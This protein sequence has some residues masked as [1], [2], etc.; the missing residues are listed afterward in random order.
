MSSLV[1]VAE[2]SLIFSNEASKRTRT[3]ISVVEPPTHNGAHTSSLRVNIAL[4]QQHPSYP[5]VSIIPP[6]PTSAKPTSIKSAT[7][8]NSTLH[9]YRFLSEHTTQQDT[10]HTIEIPELLDWDIWMVMKGS[11]F[12]RGWW[13][14]AIP[15]VLFVF[16]ANAQYVASGNLSVPL[17]QLAYQLKVSPSSHF[18]LRY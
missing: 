13:K 11:V 2:L 8:D 12:G 10:E 5:V 6:T 17:F 4:A 9:P 3:S 1:V 14:L 7:T 16:Q 15:A 18:S